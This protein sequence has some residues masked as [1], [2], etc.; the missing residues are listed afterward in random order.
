MSRSQ[1]DVADILVHGWLV[2]CSLANDL[3]IEPDAPQPLCIDNKPSIKDEGGLAHHRV[4]AIIV[5]VAELVPLCADHHGI[6]IGASLVYIAADGD[7]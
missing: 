6:R 1:G 7:V 4:D 3:Y 5:Q 2:G